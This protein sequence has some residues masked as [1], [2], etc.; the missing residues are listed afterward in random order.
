MLGS[1]HFQALK[2]DWSVG[3][4]NLF[5]FSFKLYFQFFNTRPGRYNKR[6]LPKVYSVP[7]DFSWI[8]NYK[9]SAQIFVTLRKFR[10]FGSIN[11]LGQQKIGLFHIEIKFLFHIE[12]KFVCKYDISSFRLVN[13]HYIL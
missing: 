13:S 9:L 7:Q 3:R 11:I 5:H 12:I 1:S 4:H 10:Y 2:N 6:M 8:A